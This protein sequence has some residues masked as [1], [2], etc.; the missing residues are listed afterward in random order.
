MRRFVSGL[1]GYKAPKFNLVAL[2]PVSKRLGSV[3]SDWAHIN[4]NLIDCP[5]IERIEPS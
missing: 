3:W 2:D 5:L 1:S 4:A